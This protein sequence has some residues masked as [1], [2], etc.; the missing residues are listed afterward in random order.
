VV[1]AVVI[2]ADQAVV[3]WAETV[4]ARQVLVV[5]RPQTQALVVAVAEV[6]LLLVGLVV[7]ALSSSVISI[8]KVK[9]GSFC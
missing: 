6:M 4:A 5:A 7:L 8:S 1:V 9:H 3:E 2:V